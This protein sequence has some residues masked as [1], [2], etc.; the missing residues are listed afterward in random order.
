MEVCLMKDYVVNEG[1][2]I[3]EETYNLA[4]FTK[5]EDPVNESHNGQ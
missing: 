1:Q 2:F 4:I 5:F 3:E